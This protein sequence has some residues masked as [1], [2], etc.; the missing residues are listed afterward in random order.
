MRFLWL[1][2]LAG[3]VEGGKN[4]KKKSASPKSVESSSSYDAPLPIIN[5][6][7]AEAIESKLA[8]AE[9]EGSP[10][11]SFI[12]SP[13][14]SSRSS[15]YSDDFEIPSDDGVVNPVTEDIDWLGSSTGAAG[16]DFDSTYG[17]WLSGIDDKEDEEPMIV[18]RNSFD[19]LMDKIND[20]KVIERVVLFDESEDEDLP[21]TILQGSEKEKPSTEV[22]DDKVDDSP[23]FV[24]EVVHGYD[25]VIV[26]VPPSRSS[27]PDW[28][29]PV[30]EDWK[31]APLVSP[32]EIVFE[33]VRDSAGELFVLA[34]RAAE[35]TAPHLKVVGTVVASSLPLIVEAVKQFPAEKVKQG[36]VIGAAK[37][38]EV[39]VPATVHA[40]K[41]VFKAGVMCS[42]LAL[43]GIDL[44]LRA[45]SFIVDKGLQ[46]I[47]SLQDDQSNKTSKPKDEAVSLELSTLPDRQIESDDEDF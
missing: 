8:W 4:K 11:I 1:A 40:T 17:G 10:T 19:S 38:V 9:D 27:S 12:P 25:N 47:A 32:E 18:D 31:D 20:D 21:D 41:F 15:S 22:E 23:A 26:Q 45:A 28:V 6:P 42:F 34:R 3:F 5:Q 33:L 13:S 39:G 30:V 37:C 7:E 16:F 36:V 46:G 43:K 35:A 29:S 14:P 44:S 2:I 24:E